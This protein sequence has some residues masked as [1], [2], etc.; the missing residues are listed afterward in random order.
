MESTQPPA[1]QPRDTAPDARPEPAPAP[2]EP[3]PAEPAPPPAAGTGDVRRIVE[4]PDERKAG[5]DSSLQLKGA[6]RWRVENRSDYQAT[7]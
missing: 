2:A 4:T 6:S 3:A 5:L 1:E 7:V